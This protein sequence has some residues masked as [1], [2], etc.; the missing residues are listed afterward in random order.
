MSVQMAGLHQP[1]SRC[2]TARSTHTKNSS[3]LFFCAETASRKTASLKKAKL[4]HT[5][6]AVK[7][8]LFG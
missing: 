4:T 7:Q 8:R 1:K 3:A 2:F 6:T 5:V